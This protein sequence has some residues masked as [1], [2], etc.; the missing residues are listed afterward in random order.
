MA[1]ISPFSMITIKN[2]LQTSYAPEWQFNAIIPASHPNA[3]VDQT[4]PLHLFPLGDK[5]LFLMAENSNRGAL[6]VY[7]F[8]DHVFLLGTQG[9]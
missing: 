8:A 7:T 4:G 6:Q 3:P 5:G 1:D 9:L 2:F